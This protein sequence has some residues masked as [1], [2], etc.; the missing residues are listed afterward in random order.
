M[1]N[2]ENYSQEQIRET[3]KKR[4]LKVFTLKRKLT[5]IEIAG[6][7]GISIPT[8]TNNLK[9]LMDEGLIREVGKTSSNSGRK[10]SILE[11]KPNSRMAFGVDFSSNHLRKTGMIRFMLSNLDMKVIHEESFS[12]NSFPDID[13]I[14]NHL[15]DRFMT[16]LDEKS[17]NVNTVLGVCFSLP[18]IINEKEKILEKSPNMGTYLG[19]NRLD[20]KN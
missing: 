20:L 12:Y 4:I 1:H 5:R 17:I 6:E 8:I 16:I 18:G 15:R 13:E 11:F 3:N 10:A 19:I 2:V 9:S 14:M 7:T